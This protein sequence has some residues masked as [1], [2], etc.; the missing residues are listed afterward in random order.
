[1]SAKG[2]GWRSLDGLVWLARVGP[3]PADTWGAAMGWA[4]PTVRS[5][6]VRL[7]R[8]G[9]L[10]RVARLQ[11]AGGALVYASTFG[12]DTARA[13]AGVQALAVRRPPAPVTW[14]HAEACAQMGA[15]LTVRGREM[16]APRELLLDDRWLGELEWTEHGETRRRGHRP[17]FIAT[18][19]SGRSIAIELELTV[20]SAQRLR[21]VLSMY[22]AWLAE[23]RVESLLY[24]VGG[25]LEYR[26]LMRHAPD[27]GLE[28]GRRFGV[29]R[30]GQMTA[31][32]SVPDVTGSAT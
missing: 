11:S 22:V 27:V 21:A 20:K 19:A 25:Q 8:A 23:G 7:H 10:E 2:P 24:A 5:H 28:V 17:D 1:M 13:R 30:L 15:Y 6:T 29:R 26:A 9:L 4:A 14:Q 32:E 31:D 16:I 3:A 12:V 18:G